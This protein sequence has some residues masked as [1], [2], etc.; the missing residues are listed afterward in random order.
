MFSSQSKIYPLRTLAILSLIGAA[1]GCTVLT[2]NT[3][4]L[5]QGFEPATQVYVRILLGFGLSLLAF[6]KKLRIKHLITI[7]KKDI[8]LLLIMGSVGCASAIL[9]LTLAALNTKIVNVAVIEST[10]PFVVYFYSYL[11][12]K[13][14][15]R[16]KLLFSLL[17]TV[18][19]SSVVATKSF[20][21]TL[22][23]VGTGELFAIFAVFSLGWWSIGRKML[24]DH[25]NNKE[26]TV[27]TMLI[28]GLTSL[29]I[30]LLKKEPFSPQAFTLPSVIV[31]IIIGSGLNL[32][33]TYL[34]AFAF[35]NI[36]LVFGNQLL[37]T[38][39][40][41]SLI[42]GILF[43]QEFIS[44]PEFFGGFIVLASVWQA[45]KLIKTEV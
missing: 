10:V 32:V 33:I 39:I 31:G 27:I 2:M 15:V 4:L 8:F 34:E 30:A 21:P 12:F 6:R 16:P 18:Y 11:F 1:F 14:K 26:I 28:A 45:N 25:L 22:K 40:V 44:L 23:I 5:D 13:E 36:N 17:L 35:K 3:R 37:M 24:S 29:V 7:P 42:G 9:F 38:H 43:Y 41:F 20:A 19:G